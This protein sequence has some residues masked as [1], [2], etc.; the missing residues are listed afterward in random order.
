MEREI[1]R[2]IGAVAAVMRSL[3]RSIVVKRELSR[4]AKLSIYQSVYIPTLTY[5]GPLP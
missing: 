1:D 5:G 4:K 2:R 3:Y